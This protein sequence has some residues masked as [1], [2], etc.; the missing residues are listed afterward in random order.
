MV[1][2]AA[3]EALLKGIAKAGGDGGEYR[4]I[5]ALNEIKIQPRME[6]IPRETQMPLWDNWSMLL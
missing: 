2:K 6:T 3:N 1:P 5:E 4:G